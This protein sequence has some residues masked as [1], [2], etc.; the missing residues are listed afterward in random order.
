MNIKEQF[1]TYILKIIVLSI[2]KYHNRFIKISECAQAS[3]KVKNDLYNE[4]CESPKSLS[5][6][7]INL[8]NWEP[9]SCLLETYSLH[10]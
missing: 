6:Y 8:I 9:R 10:F 1:Y 4:R 2:K 5:Q 3:T 7:S